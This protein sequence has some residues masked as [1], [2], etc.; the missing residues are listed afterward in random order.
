MITHIETD[1]IKVAA[2][3]VSDRGFQAIWRV[4]KREVSVDFQS[5]CGYRLSVSAEIWVDDRGREV[6]LQ[7][8]VKDVSTTDSSTSSR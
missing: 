4:K 6:Q 7:L 1:S 8:V 3:A 2:E 5:L